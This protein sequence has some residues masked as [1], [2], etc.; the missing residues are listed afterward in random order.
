MYQQ[1]TGKAAGAIY[2]RFLALFRA[3]SGEIDLDGWFPDPAEVVATATERLREVGLSRQKIA[4]LH[5][6]A[7]HFDEGLLSTNRFHAWTDAE[8]VEHLIQVKGI[9][10]WSAEIFLMMYLRRPNV[11]PVN[12]VGLNRAMMNLY[13]LEEMPNPEKIHELSAPWHPW[14]SAACLY[15]WR[16]LSIDLP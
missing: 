3:Q 9:G 8:I 15:L 12:D 10:R 2:G 13:E 11:F 16:S 6:L 1:I 4:A 5:D 7:R 14:R